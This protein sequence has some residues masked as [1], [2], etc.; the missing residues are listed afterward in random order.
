MERIDT[1]INPRWSIPVEPVAEVREGLSLAID[2]GRIVALLPTQEAL[3]R[4][5]PNAVH[6]R[7]DHLLIPGLVNAH[8]HAA[9]TLFR[10]Y[11]DDIPLG[12]WLDERIWPAE[13]RWVSPDFIADGTRLAVAEMLRG[14]TAALQ[15]RHARHTRAHS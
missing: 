3:A 10:G 7:P 15:Q 11:A 5:A 9:M 12:Q 4:Y 1:L 6:E 14:A 8:T 13:G 2:K